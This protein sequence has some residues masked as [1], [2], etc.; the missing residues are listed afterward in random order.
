MRSGAAFPSVR[1]QLL[2]GTQSHGLP[3]SPSHLKG[4]GNKFDAVG[5]ILLYFFKK[6]DSVSDFSLETRCYL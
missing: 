3:S 4:A 1:T 5:L 2:S 6:M